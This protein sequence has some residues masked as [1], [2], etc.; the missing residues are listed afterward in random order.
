METCNRRLSGA[1][2]SRKVLPVTSGYLLTTLLVTFMLAMPPVLMAQSTDDSENWKFGLELYGWLPKISGDTASGSEIDVGQGELLD[3]L[4]MTLQGIV[5]VSKGKWSFTVDAVYL[6][7]EDDQYGSS[8]ESSGIVPTNTDVDLNTWI[9]T[10]TI[11]YTVLENEK[12]K[13]RIIGGVRYL[14]LDLDVDVGI[15][16][17]PPQT[18]SISYSGDEWDGII[19]VNG[20]IDL[21]EQWYLP[22][23][24]DIGTG[25][26]DLTWQAALAVGYRFSSFD[27]LAGYRYLT[28]DFDDSPA[29]D[30][31]TVHGPY[32]GFKLLF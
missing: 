5:G 6:S 29:L 15:A 3:V 13:L 8:T 28:W 30:D 19:G 23:Y 4:Q 10:P 7:V 1:L 21:N 27:V 16:T 32:V 14:S 17:S 25:D 26:S 9:V 31:L 18:P 12:S 24:L 2:Q 11:G 22:F 20:H